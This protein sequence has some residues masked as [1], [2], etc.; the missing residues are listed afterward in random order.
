MI[1]AVTYATSDN[2]HY[3]MEHVD[4][5]FEMCDVYQAGVYP[6]DKI[7]LSR[8]DDD[9]NEAYKGWWGD[10]RYKITITIEKV[11]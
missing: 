8:I 5:S 1:E 7:T 9:L 3:V 11:K 4:H 10:N 6:D 2:I